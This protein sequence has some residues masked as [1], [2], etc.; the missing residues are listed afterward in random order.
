MALKNK[1]AYEG[2]QEQVRKIK[3]PIIE[4]VENKYKDRTY[5]V[6][7]D[8]Q[9][10]SCVCPRTGMPDY[11]VFELD[12]VPGKLLVELKSLKLYLTAFRNMGIFHENVVNRVS[13]D[14]IKACRPRYLKVKGIF[15]TRGGIK[16]S[17]IRE[18]GKLR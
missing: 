11:A 12:Y 7:L 9:E 5:T 14:F 15:N 6:H 1:S 10:F 18:Y 13:D 4:A 16:A 17:V 3:L 2:R 8:I